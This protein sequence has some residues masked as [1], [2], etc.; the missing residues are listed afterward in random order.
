MIRKIL[1]NVHL[2]LGLGLGLYVVMIGLTGSILVFGD[3]IDAALNPHLLRVEPQ[4][5]RLP[6]S[7][8]LASLGR[9]YPGQRIKSI[10]PPATSTGVYSLS[11]GKG[12]AQ[13]HI[14]LNPYTAQVTGTRTRLGSLVGFVSDLHLNLLWAAAGRTLNGWA[15]LLTGVLLVS[16]IVLWWPATWQQFKTRARVQKGASLRRLMHDWH[17]V[18]GFYTFAI[19]LLTVLTGAI[20]VFHEPVKNAVYGLTGAREDAKVA[21]TPIAGRKPLSPDELLHIGEAALPAPVT[22]GINF[23][24]KPTDPFVLLREWADGRQWGNYGQVWIDQYSGR[25]LNIYD[26]RRGHFGR[27]LMRMDFP[28]HAGIW[29]GLPTKILYALAGLSPLVLFVT[30]IWKWNTKRLGRQR[31]RAR[32]D[33]AP[34]TVLEE[35]TA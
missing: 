7:A 22:F 26:S 17:N 12:A 23:P 15:A 16:G 34:A 6:I 25:V 1:F 35:Q 8:V 32:R 4:G 20:F 3:E 27:R 19:L 33:A 29:G 13:R 28:L 18:S 31:N 24:S 11:L 21:S 10:R 30:G 9:A 2:W 14:Y 5:E